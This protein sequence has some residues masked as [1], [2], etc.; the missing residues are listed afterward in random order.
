MSDPHLPMELRLDAE[1]LA[2]QLADDVRAGL[3]AT[4][5]ALAPKYFYDGHGSDLFEAITRLPEYYP[6]RTEAGILA[7]RAEEIA[8]VSDA[9]TLLELGS[10]TSEKTRT[11]LSALTESGTLRRFVPFDVDP[12]VL[13]E[14]AAS[15]GAEFPGLLVEPEVGDFEKH[16]GDL[17]HHPRTMVAFL[18]STIGNFTRAQRTDFLASVRAMLRE[19]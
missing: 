5:K 3:S 8:K 14:A 2:R 12:A 1:A 13:E 10:G 7:A 15:I 4:P 19:G 17:P 9:E 11:L 16:L 18:G 6:T